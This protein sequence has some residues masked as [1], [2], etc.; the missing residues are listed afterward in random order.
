MVAL[1]AMFVLD[2]DGEVTSAE[3]TLLHVDPDISSPL[4]QTRRQQDLHAVTTHEAVPGG[5]LALEV[6]V[7]RHLSDALSNKGRD[8]VDRHLPAT[9]ADQFNGLV[10]HLNLIHT[11]TNPRRAPDLPSRRNAAEPSGQG[12]ERA[13]LPGWRRGGT[14]RRPRDTCPVSTT[15]EP[16]R[17]V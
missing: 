4:G 1:R 2:V 5:H 11:W 17:D 10:G 13:S 16:E 8:E 6:G 12:Q 14:E 15:Q 9:T 3:H 7:D